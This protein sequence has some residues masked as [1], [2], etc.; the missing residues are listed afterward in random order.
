MRATKKPPVLLSCGSTR[1]P[2]PRRSA[3]ASAGGGGKSAGRSLQ[4]SACASVASARLETEE[5]SACA[6]TRHDVKPGWEMNFG[7]SGAIG[8]SSSPELQPSAA[9]STASFSMGESEHVE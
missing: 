4:S 8:A 7:M 9:A 2:F 1:I 5:P 3:A 6:A